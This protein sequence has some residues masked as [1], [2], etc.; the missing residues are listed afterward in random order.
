MIPDISNL[1]VHEL[2]ELQMDIEN[3]ISKL[4]RAERLNKKHT[5]AEIVA[6][7]AYF[8]YVVPKGA[9]IWKVRDLERGGAYGMEVGGYEH[10][11][12]VDTTD[13]KVLLVVDDK[14]YGVH[15]YSDLWL[16]DKIVI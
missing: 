1:Q 14:D 6:M 13:F 9:T 5:K 15:S 11:C 12:H 2:E 16:T 3:Q 8:G 7:F 10:S 4:K